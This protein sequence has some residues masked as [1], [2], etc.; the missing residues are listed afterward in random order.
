[1]NPKNIIRRIERKLATVIR[2]LKITLDGRA[3]LIPIPVRIAA[4][5]RRNRT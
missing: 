5:R 4:D 2:S 1:M 3:V